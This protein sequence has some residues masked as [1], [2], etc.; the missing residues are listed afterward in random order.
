MRLIGEILSQV[1]ADVEAQFSRGEGG[2]IRAASCAQSDAGRVRPLDV[3]EG[4]VCGS[5]SL[6]CHMT[7]PEGARVGQEDAFLEPEARSPQA[8]GPTR[9]RVAGGT[10]DQCFKSPVS[11]Y[12]TDHTAPAGRVV[13]PKTA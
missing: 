1:L 7:S 11:A 12:T 6:T 13:H 3:R 8:K 9:V 10:D 2:G 4:K 5:A